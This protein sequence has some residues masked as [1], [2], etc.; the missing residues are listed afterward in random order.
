MRDLSRLELVGKTLL[1]AL[2]NLAVVSPQW[3]KAVAPVDWLERYNKRWEEYQLPKTKGKRYELG[4]QVGQDG[5]F[6][7][8]AIY[9]AESPTWL[10]EIPA[11][12][13]L[14]QVWIQ[15]FYE[16]EGQLHWRLAGNIPPA[17]KSICSPFDTQ[18]RYNIKRETEWVGYKVHLTET[19]GAEEPHL[20]THVVTTAATE[21]DTEVVDD[22]HVAL[23]EKN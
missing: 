22:L 21:Q 15:N 4:A 9:A 17:A 23:A 19:C 8:Q 11:V 18:A 6:L 7:L 2:N 1:H 12:Q 20:I 13:T 3:L 16:E 5:F 14:R 10:L